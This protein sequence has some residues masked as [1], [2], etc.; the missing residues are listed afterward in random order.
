M[1]IGMQK[2]EIKRLQTMCTDPAPQ[3]KELST[4]R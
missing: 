1:E 2:V 3:T 4:Q